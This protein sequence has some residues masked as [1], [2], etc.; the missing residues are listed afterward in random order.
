MER[1]YWTKINGSDERFGGSEYVRGRINGFMEV[2][3][4]RN[5]TPT[6][7]DPEN[8]DA[9]ISVKCTEYEYRAFRKYVEKFYPGLCEFDVEFEE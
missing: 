8:G 6:F 5:F 4:G 1:I 2:L 3:C 7:L 9:H